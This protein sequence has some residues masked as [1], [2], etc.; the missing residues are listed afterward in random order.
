[1][2]ETEKSILIVII[3]LIAVGSFLRVYGV[4]EVYTEYD[5][6]GV[7]SIH[8]A[9]IG[10][11]N[12]NPTKSLV[13]YPI[14]VDMESVNSIENNLL[15]P[16]YIAY[17]WTYAPAQYIVL[18]L[19]LD[20]EDTFE[21]A[22]L[23]GRVV[24]AIF[25]ISGICLLA[26]LM[27]VINGHLL[28]WII[29]V[30]ISIPIFSANSILYAH[31][32][33]PYSAYFFSTTLGLF[34]LFKYFTSRISFRQIVIF[35]SLLLYLS[36]L[37]VLFA[38]PVLLIYLV[39]WKKEEDL[40]FSKNLSSDFVTI[41]IGF[42]I[43][44]PALFI[45]K[46]NS[47]GKGI[48]PPEYSGIASLR[49]ISLH[50]INQISVSIESMMYGFFRHDYIFTLLAFLFALILVKKIF[51]S[52]KRLSKS[53]VYIFSTLLILLQWLILHFFGLL[54]LDETRHMLIIL[55]LF[56]LL[57]FYVLR[58]FVI[59]SYSL[60]FALS[61]L[62]IASSASIYSL[63]LIESKYSNFDYDFLNARNESVILLYRSTLGP[64]KYY[65]QSD[66]KVYFIDMQSFQNH[67]TKMDF[68][69]EILLV[70]QQAE[71]YD[72]GLYEK[73]K[74]SLPGL[75]CNYSLKDLY[76]KESGTYFTYNNY[77][78]NSNKNGMFVYQMKKNNKI[79]C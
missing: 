43:S 20:E 79:E 16:F 39:K 8:K 58:N 4:K 42:V 17:T 56:T 65:D 30:V 61:I 46:S 49:D 14:Q 62:L 12:I 44:L 36:Y 52:S 74:N 78:A 13:D 48:M 32:M 71:I 54:P 25:S 76:L 51:F 5:D 15:L 59:K 77:P 50:F 41:L 22:V 27:Y 19:L 60:I 72:E 67:Y 69:D 23:K 64:L 63:N 11:K 31:H 38:L 75:F 37:T 10:S 35:L 70:S 2:L 28:T 66:K 3:I 1:M 55:P 73:Y 7:I 47:G 29:P 57:V 26:Y 21:E 45:L 33:S 18:P 34:L 9:H 6:I 24:S 53:S 68:P 40:H